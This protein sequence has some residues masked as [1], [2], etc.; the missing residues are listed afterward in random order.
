MNEPS[1]N[2]IAMPAVVQSLG[3]H[4]LCPAVAFW[5]LRPT[6]SALGRTHC[7]FVGTPPLPE[8]PGRSAATGTRATRLTPRAGASAACL[9]SG[10]ANRTSLRGGESSAHSN[11]SKAPCEHFSRPSAHSL[12]AP[13]RPSPSAPPHPSGAAPAAAEGEE[14]LPG[15]SPRRPPPRAPFNHSPTNSSRVEPHRQSNATALSVGPQVP[16]RSRYTF[17]SSFS[18]EAS[19]FP[20]TA[21]PF[22]FA[23]W[24]Y[25]F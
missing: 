1:A 11:E 20:C 15:P 5:C 25:A 13:P 8:D 19:Y 6:G 16:R 17:A 14:R 10:S 12:P 23:R 4:E 22:I 24:K 2:V 9:R 21:N 18:I 7:A 3:E